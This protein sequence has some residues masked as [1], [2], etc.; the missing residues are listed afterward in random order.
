MG[1]AV[2]VAVAAACVVAAVLLALTS[3]ARAARARRDTLAAELARSRAD[4]AALSGR[5]AV[6]AE[7]LEETRRTAAADHQ[8]VIT[9]LSGSGG[10]AGPAG[11]RA[12]E[13]SGNDVVQAQLLPPRRPSRARRVEDRLVDGLAGSG[14]SASGRLADLLVRTVALGHGLRRALAPEVLDRAAAESH[15]ARRRSRRDRRRELRD[16]RRLLRDGAAKAQDVA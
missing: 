16:A 15:V 11:S 7:E 8:Y 2:L 14:S 10:V 13:P 9:S 6:L 5:V 1:S 12:A 3:T 4:V